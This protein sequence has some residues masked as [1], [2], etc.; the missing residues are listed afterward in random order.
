MIPLD[1]RSPPRKN[2]P[3]EARDSL[4][5]LDD[6][7]KLVIPVEP[8]DPFF[9]LPGKTDLE[10]TLL[11]IHLPAT[12]MGRT[13][14]VRRIPRLP[15]NEAQD[16]FIE[17][18]RRLLGS[19]LRKR[20]PRKKPLT[21]SLAWKC[22]HRLSRH[23]C[24][25]NESRT[26]LAKRRL[27]EP[28]KTPRL[29]AHTIVL[30]LDGVRSKNPRFTRPTQHHDLLSKAQKILPNKPFFNKKTLHFPCKKPNNVPS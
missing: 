13:D 10:S 26:L 24:M 18:K 12:V 27:G 28:A 1:D 21:I 7:L 9:R 20:K 29:V 23:G 11:N 17:R 14:L 19:P 8:R 4:V 5:R 22:I 25:K 3:P 6:F 30:P 2:P 16:A 15:T